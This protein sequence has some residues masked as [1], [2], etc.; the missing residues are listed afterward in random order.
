MVLIA[1]ESSRFPVRA[2]TKRQTQLN[3]YPTSAAIMQPAWVTW[4]MNFTNLQFCHCIII[5][6]VK[7]F[8]VLHRSINSVDNFVQDYRAFSKNVSKISLNYTCNTAVQFMFTLYYSRGIS[9]RK[10][11]FTRFIL[12]SLTTNI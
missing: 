8:I 12:Y 3:T 4:A 7:D 11:E 5:I 2:Q 10:A 9:Y 1:Q 6:V